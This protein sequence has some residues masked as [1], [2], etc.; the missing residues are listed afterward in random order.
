MLFP[1]LFKILLY[2]KSLPLFTLKIEN[3]IQQKKGNF[4]MPFQKGQNN[5]SELVQ[6]VQT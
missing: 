6:K 5:R 3:K 1:V 2:R 4:R